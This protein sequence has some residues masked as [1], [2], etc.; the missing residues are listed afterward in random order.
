MEST[1][2]RQNTPNNREQTSICSIFPALS[3]ID[4]ELEKI[5]SELSVLSVAFSEDAQPDSNSTV[6]VLIDAVERIEAVQ[7]TITTLGK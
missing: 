2:Y 6:F 5:K 1:T 7:K 4:I 3:N